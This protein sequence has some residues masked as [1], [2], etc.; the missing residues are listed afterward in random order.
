[1][2]FSQSI[3]REKSEVEGKERER[4]DLESNAQ[5]PRALLCFHIFQPRPRGGRSQAVVV[6]QLVFFTHSLVSGHGEKSPE[7][8]KQGGRGSR[9]VA[10]DFLW[11]FNRARERER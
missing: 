6:R 11:P 7:K 9:S 2:I 1:M 4:E 8:D 10:D 5:T 3:S